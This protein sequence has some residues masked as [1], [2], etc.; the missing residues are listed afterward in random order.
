VVFI[1]T[2]AYIAIRV[3]KAWAN[4]P[5][6]HF[7]GLLETIKVGRESSRPQPALLLSTQTL[8]H[9]LAL[10]E[11][12]NSFQPYLFGPLPASSPDLAQRSIIEAWFIGSHADIGGGSREDGLSLYPL[13]WMLLESR[14]HGLILEPSWNSQSLTEEPLGLVFPL[15]PDQNPSQQQQPMQPWIFQYKNGIEIEMV[16]L[17]TSH[18]H[19]NLQ[20]DKKKILQKGPSRRRTQLDDNNSAQTHP[21]SHTMSN[22]SYKSSWKD[23]F[24]LSRKSSRT[25]VGSAPLTRQPEID[26]L[27][28]PI[29]EDEFVEVGPRPHTV[30]INSGPA[31]V[32]LFSTPRRVFDSRGL[33][34]YLNKGESFI[35]WIGEIC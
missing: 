31:L 8:R 3:A 22:Q 2:C 1:F 35:L 20:A 13:Q 32:S 28:S 23:R 30:Q 27:Y 4:Q 15:V 19:G 24:R 9:A 26:S 5:A 14:A 18:R 34:G 6:I 33:I 25:T 11:T 12:R 21:L 10:N 17:R 16:D 7:L 29:I